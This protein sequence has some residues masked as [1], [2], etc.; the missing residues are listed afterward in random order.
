MVKTLP[1]VNINQTLPNGTHLFEIATSSKFK[2]LCNSWQI[3]EIALFGSIL[4]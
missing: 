4:W 3:K 1:I 2:K